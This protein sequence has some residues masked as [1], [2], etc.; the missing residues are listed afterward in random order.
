MRCSVI[1]VSETLSTAAAPAPAV[2]S[3][4]GPRLG[5]VRLDRSRAGKRG[6]GAPWAAGQLDAAIPH[7]A[8]RPTRSHPGCGH[9]PGCP[10]PQCRSFNGHDQLHRARAGAQTPGGDAVED[11]IRVA[12]V[13]VRS[14]LSTSDGSMRGYPRRPRGGYALLVATAS[15][16]LPR[17]VGY[18]DLPDLRLVSDDPDFAGA[19]ALAAVLPPGAGLDRTRGG[20]RSCRWRPISAGRCTRK[21]PTGA[22]G[23]PCR[24]GSDRD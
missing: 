17:V 9:R 4:V 22:G 16:V 7:P 2:R 21:S 18:K 20:E 15:A 10:S 6:C 12:C 24:R 13:R 14:G 23:S 11:G 8:W 1:C 19:P 5:G 3:S